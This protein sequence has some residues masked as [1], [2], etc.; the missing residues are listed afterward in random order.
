MA[1]FLMRVFLVVAASTTHGSD[2]LTK[3]I[4]PLCRRSLGTFTGWR[5]NDSWWRS[6]RHQW[7]Y[8]QQLY[9]IATVRRLTAFY[10]HEHNAVMP[11]SAFE[12]QTPDEMYF[13]RGERVPDELAARRVDARRDRPRYRAL[14]RLPRAARPP[15]ERNRTPAG[16]LGAFVQCGAQCGPLCASAYMVH[17][18]HVL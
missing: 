12:G 18:S 1:S 3:G 7:L 4:S 9:T 5:H 2:V 8:L 10:V 13:G 14:D 15:R 17:R 6:L 11:H 16:P